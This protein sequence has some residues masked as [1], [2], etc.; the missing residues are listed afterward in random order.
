MSSFQRPN[1]FASHAPG[2]GGQPN[3]YRNDYT[4]QAA[5]GNS[6][7]AAYDNYGG[8]RFGHGPAAT[9]SQPVVVQ[10]TV[11]ENPQTVENVFGESIEVA[12]NPLLKFITNKGGKLTCS[13]N[14]DRADAAK[15]C[16]ENL[17]KLENE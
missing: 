3:L 10:E 8:G 15:K 14:Y 2:F 5:F 4:R 9:P 7:G 6:S 11:L 16:L 12:D 1:K 17:K 13:P